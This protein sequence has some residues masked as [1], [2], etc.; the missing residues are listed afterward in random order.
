L[1]S[2]YLFSFD[3]MLWYFNLFFF[4]I[5]R[6]KHVYI[7]FFQIKTFSIDDFN[8]T[9]HTTHL[10]QQNNYALVIFLTEYHS[11]KVWV[12]IS[13]FVSV[14]RKKKYLNEENTTTRWPRK[15]NSRQW[16]TYCAYLRRR[17][18]II[19]LILLFNAEKKW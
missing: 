12:I 1:I 18:T 6:F 15:M 8:K 10:N 4:S 19:I 5:T 14:I 11:S 17:V 9:R 7:L 16:C 2:H 3:V 13:L